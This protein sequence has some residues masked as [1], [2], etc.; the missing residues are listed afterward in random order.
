M[1]EPTFR[2]PR[3]HGPSTLKY[4]S[5]MTGDPHAA[6]DLLQETYYRFLART[7]PSPATPIDGTTCSGSRSTSCGGSARVARPVH[8]AAA[9]STREPSTTPADPAVRTD[10]SRAM[11]R[12]RPRERALLWLAYARKARRIARSPACS[13]S[14]RRASRCCSSGRAGSWRLFWAMEYPVCRTECPREQEA[15][16]AIVSRRWPGRA[17]I[18]LRRHVVTCSVCADLIDV[19]AALADDHERASG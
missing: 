2:A 13:A 18:D 16:D 8:G 9:G 4:L 15:L 17:D 7:E 1:D 14:R 12:L 6:D 3:T 11:G 19:A 10:V 5:R